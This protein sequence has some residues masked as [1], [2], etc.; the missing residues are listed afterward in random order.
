MKHC[1]ALSEG[2]TQQKR[3]TPK[4]TKA[5]EELIPQEKNENRPERLCTLKITKTY[6]FLI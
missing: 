6:T 5:I 1:R 4:D 3:A 2:K